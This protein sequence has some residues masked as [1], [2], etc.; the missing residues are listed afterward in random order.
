M[1]SDV[2]V[3]ARIEMRM[4]SYRLQFLDSIK[5]I[6]SREKKP[7]RPCLSST[8]RLS[9]ALSFTRTRAGL[10]ITRASDYARIRTQRV[11][12]V[13]QPSGNA[14]NA[15]REQFIRARACTS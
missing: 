8:F 1:S 15:N 11:V 5:S 9:F 13:L 14:I 10:C 2:Y 7:T 12:T 3:C 4:L 6:V